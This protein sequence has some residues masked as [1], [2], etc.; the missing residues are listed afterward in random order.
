M[1]NQLINRLN[2]L[3]LLG[4]T[5]I[6]AMGSIIQLVF[7]ELPCP[8]CLLQRIGFMMVMFGFMLNIRFGPQQ[9]HYGIIL[10]G[11]LFG[12]IAALRQVSLHLLPND[13]GYG[14]PLLGMHYYTWAFVIFVM[15]IVGVAVL[16]CLWRQEKN[17]A[18]H[19]IKNIGKLACY[20]AVIVVLINIVSTFIMTGPHVTP[21]DPHSYWLL[22][23]FKK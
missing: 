11:A 12:A 17:T 3:G 10:L 8:L 15:T 9:P 22:D 2:I 13:P 6:L 5:A 20:L 21:A 4:I 14:S 23:Q 7:H 16:L 19:R 18:N 1:N